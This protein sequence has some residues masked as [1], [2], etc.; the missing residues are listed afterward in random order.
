MFF[1]GGHQGIERTEVRGE[2]LRRALANH[3]DA[4]AEDEPFEREFL[5]GRDLREQVL[6]A[7]FA[8]AV[9]RQQLLFPQIVKVGDVGHQPAREKLV[10]QGL[11]EAFDVHHLAR[12]EV[13]EAFAQPRRAV[14]V[15]AEAVDLTLGAHH[16]AAALRAVCGHGEILRAARVIFVRHDA[17]HLGDDVAA[18]LDHHMVA[19]AHAQPFDFILIV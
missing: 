6:H 14:D 18:A 3:A 17:R 8:H 19:N 5:R 11:A 10:H 12:G 16:V 15:D 13:Q 1:A 2:K 7:L 4:K 9:E